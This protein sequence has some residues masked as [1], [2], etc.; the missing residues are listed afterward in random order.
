MKA[1]LSQLQSE[2]QQNQLLIT[3]KVKEIAHLQEKLSEY[4]DD[5]Q[6]PDQWNMEENLMDAEIVIHLHS[7]A[8]RGKEAARPDWQELRQVLHRIHPAFFTNLLSKGNLNDKEMNVC[9]LIRLRFIPSEISV[10]TDSS[11]Q[12]ITNIRVRLLNKMF[13]QTGGAR[14]FDELIRSL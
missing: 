9:M 13:H 14:Q 5:R 1:E 7:L 12:S 8:S 3:E 6:K 2:R 4:Q 10:L 11:P